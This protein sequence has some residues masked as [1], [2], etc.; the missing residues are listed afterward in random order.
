MILMTQFKTAVS[1][2]CRQY[3]YCSFALSHRYGTDRITVIWHTGETLLITHHLQLEPI[4]PLGRVVCTGSLSSTA[5]VLLGGWWCA[6]ESCHVPSVSIRFWLF[7]IRAEAVSAVSWSFLIVACL[8]R[9]ATPIAFKNFT[10]DCPT[11]PRKPISTRYTW[12]YQPVFSIWFFRSWCFVA[13]LSW[14]HSIVA[15]HGTVSLASI[16][17]HSASDHITMFGHWRIWKMCL[18]NLKALPRSTSTV[19][20]DWT[21]TNA[22]QPSTCLL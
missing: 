15:T 19:H 21:D 13:F 4:P 20:S 5:V 9:G 10:A 18:G 16:T 8:M 14:A 2:L 22:V 11:K 12:H 1:L 6:C 7:Q 17:Q 3:R